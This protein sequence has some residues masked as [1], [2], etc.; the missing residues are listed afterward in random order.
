MCQA[1]AASRTF[2]E[3]DAELIFELCDAAAHGGER[4]LHA[5][6]RLRK[7]VCL[8]DFREEHQG[9]QVGHS[10]VRPRHG[11]ISDSGKPFPVIPLLRVSA[12]VLYFASGGLEADQNYER[13]R[14]GSGRSAREL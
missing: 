1:K 9:V 14:T 5:S 12:P 6:G 7:A 3:T 10:G 11:I 13:R 4:N 8:D 2:E